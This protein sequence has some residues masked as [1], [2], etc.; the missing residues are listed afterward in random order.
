MCARY[1]VL[2]AAGACLFLPQ[3][4]HAEIVTSHLSSD[5]EMVA[6]LSD[7]IFVAEGRIGDRG[8]S[9]TH[10]LDLGYSTGSPDV[11]SDYDWQNGIPVSFSLAYDFA[12]GLVTYTLGG[13]VLNYTTPYSG[14]GDLF[15]RTRA[16]PAG[17]AITV[18]DLVIGGQPL[19]ETSSAVGSGGL[20]ILWISGISAASGFTLEGTVV[21]SWSGSSPTQSNLAFQIKAA[22]LSTVGTESSSWGGIK[23]LYR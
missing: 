6:L 19:T 9:A 17:S 20:D 23:S 5:A 18:Y 11:T 2:L 1:L 13:T 21:L 8:G 3:F 4:T 22:S 7:T 16:N 15:I 10:E 12:T 14:F